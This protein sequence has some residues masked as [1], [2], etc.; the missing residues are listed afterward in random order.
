MA[1]IKDVAKLAGVSPS[2]ASR[3]MHDSSLISEETKRKV[4]HAMQ[5]LDYSPNF[6]AQNLANQSSN[7]IGVILPA[8]EEAV[9]ENPF[10]IQIIQG[11]ASICNAHDY[12]VAVASGQTDEEL[13]KNLE[14]MIKRGNITRFVFVYSQV[15]DPV[16]EFIKQQK[17]TQYVVIGSPESDRDQTCYVDN[18]N[19]LAGYDA[20]RYLL[21]KGFETVI[22]AYTNLDEGVQNA[23][24]LGY[25]Q[26]LNEFKLPKFPLEL[27]NRIADEAKNAQALRELLKKV[28]GRIAVLACDDILALDIQYL[29]DLC[30]VDPSK[31]AMMGFNNSGLAKIARPTLTSVEIFPRFLGTEAAALVINKDKDTFKLDLNRVIV[32]HKIIER[33]S[34]R[35]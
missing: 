4:R 2:T 23:R 9:G 24:Y 15:N 3:A 16:L 5:E 19:H 31:I 20:T 17:Q 11:L 28:S 25:Q 32:P 35:F 34:T 7:T 30:E 1:T 10:F 12:L 14:T 26:A 27:S 13:I 21:E 29:W 6:A 18:D 22:Y 33:D 8:R